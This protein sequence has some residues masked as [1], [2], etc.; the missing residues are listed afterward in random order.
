MGDEGLERTR[1][2]TKFVETQPVPDALLVDCLGRLRG[3]RT[4]D[5]PSHG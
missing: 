3:V 2:F 5:S 1:S 4:K